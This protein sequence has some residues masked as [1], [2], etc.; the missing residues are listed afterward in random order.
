MKISNAHQKIRISTFSSLRRCTR[1]NVFHCETRARR[2]RQARCDSRSRDILEMPGRKIASVP[3]RG[4]LGVYHGSRW[5]SRNRHLASPHSSRVT[6][7]GD[8]L[9][10]SNLW[11]IAENPSDTYLRV[12]EHLRRKVF[13]AC[14]PCSRN[15]GN[16][17]GVFTAALTVAVFR[18][19]ENKFLCSYNRTVK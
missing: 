8:R 19:S 6:A 17:R 12:S 2:E 11:R 14:T 18:A 1:R 4:R 13:P 9:A 3:G 15:A 16:G 7:L 5:I 10:R